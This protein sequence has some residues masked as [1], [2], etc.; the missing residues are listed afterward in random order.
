MYLLDLVSYLEEKYIDENC[1]NYLA[2]VLN[3]II[4][5]KN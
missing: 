3:T 2:K 1:I 4:R 5:V